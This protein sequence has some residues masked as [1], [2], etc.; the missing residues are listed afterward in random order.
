MAVFLMATSVG[1]QFFKV[2]VAYWM[3]SNPGVVIHVV[4][5]GACACAAFFGAAYAYA[6]VCADGR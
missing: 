3:K 2:P 4:S 5:A 1:A 6:R